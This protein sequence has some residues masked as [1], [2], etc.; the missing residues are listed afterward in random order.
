[1]SVSDQ[2]EMN[3]LV[4]DDDFEILKS[5]GNFLKSQNHRVHLSSNGQTGLEI[6]KRENID[7]L[8]TDVV[9]PQMDGFEILRQARHISPDTETMMITAHKDLE[10]AF[11]AMREGAVDFFTKPLKVQDLH[12]SL[13]RTV[14]FRTLSREKK[15]AQERLHQ[16][17]QVARQRYGL[18]A[19]VGESLAIKQVK[20]QI[21]QVAA[22]DLTTVL[23]QGETGTGK[24]MVAHAVHYESQRAH[25]P[26]VA[27][28]CSAI[29]ETLLENEFY[30][31]EKGAF[32]DAK[33]IHR[34]YFE[35]ADGGTLF[36]DE[37]GDMN[38]SMQAKLLRTLE[39][40]SI[41]RVGSTKE[42]PVDVRIISAT[43][44][45]LAQAVSQRQFRADLYH[46][47][48]V[49][50]IYMPSL[51]QRTADIIPLAQHFLTRFAREMRKSILGFTP[52]ATASLSAHVF[53]GN[54]RMLRNTIERACILCQSEHITSA[55]LQDSVSNLP[56]PV[57][58][59]PAQTNPPH[60]KIPWSQITSLNIET[61][62]QEAIVEALYRSNDNYALAANMLGISEK[63]LYRRRKKY[64]M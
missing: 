31:H 20:A 55:D 23:I 22:S 57:Q 8:I 30:G 34:G 6:L 2:I 3:I 17:D 46:R 13:Q 37:I 61:L 59:N 5:L 53:T 9:M 25:G 15:R 32:T 24:E 38:L 63:A 56:H 18:D 29:P 10:N 62:E 35:Q 50:C 64:K 44:R 54:V 14:R 49:F 36:L 40:R 27:V 45:D 47:L 12:A 58:S 39:E 60:T 1:M 11:R 26:F 19:I 7:I 28:D 16:I 42:M 52:E 48:N 33:Q 43:N 4:I 21:T 51:Q 41:R